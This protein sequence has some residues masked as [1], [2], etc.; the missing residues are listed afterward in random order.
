MR[1]IATAILLL[2]AAL[3]ATAETGLSGRIS[4]P[5]G[6]LVSGATVRLQNEAKALSVETKSD[7]EG[8]YIF[9]P[10]P[11]GAYRL[12]AKT[13]GLAS[14]HNDITISS[15]RIVTLDLT[16]SEVESQ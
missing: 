15:G 5:Q 7:A 10:V 9:R 4:D 3:A 16:F 2:A 12:T 6:K 1:I 8:L 14:I 13:P 11:A